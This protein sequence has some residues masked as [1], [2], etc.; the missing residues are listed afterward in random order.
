MTTQM[1]LRGVTAAQVVAALISAAP[2]G[3]LLYLAAFRQLQVPSLLEGGAAVVALL[4]WLSRA[5][6]RAS[7]R[8][9]CDD[10]AVH[11]RGEAVPYKTITSV[12]V[13]RGPRRD[14]LIIERG[15]TVKLELVLRDAFAG[16]L[17]PLDHL[18]K[19]LADVGHHEPMDGPQKRND[20]E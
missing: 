13:E 1:R 7:Y 19:K 20:S 2:L 11:M 10:I 6:A 4:P 15:Q 16:R 18:R 12:R 9:K 17:K 8:A 14:V 5:V 3:Y